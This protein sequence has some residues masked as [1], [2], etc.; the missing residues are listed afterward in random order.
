MLMTVRTSGIWYCAV[1]AGDSW[2]SQ[3][4]LQILDGGLDGD[5]TQKTSGKSTSSLTHTFNMVMGPGSEETQ[6]G[7][8]LTV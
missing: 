4:R 6:V 2:K 1:D 8:L 7:L 3:Q 5:G